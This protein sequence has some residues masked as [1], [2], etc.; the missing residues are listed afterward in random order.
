LLGPAGRLFKTFLLSR[1]GS[2]NLVT[3]IASAPKEDLLTLKELIEAGKV[4]PVIDRRYPLSETAEAIRYLATGHARAK[5]IIN[6][7]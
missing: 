3:F 6:V 5:V 7:A 4:T 1:L 2:K